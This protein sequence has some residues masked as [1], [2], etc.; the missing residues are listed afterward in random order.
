MGDVATGLALTDSYCNTDAPITNAGGSVNAHG[1]PKT[2]AELR[3]PTAHSTT[4]DETYYRWN[5]DDDGELTDLA[6]E[7]VWD[8][9]TS[10]QFPVLKADLDGDGVATV[11]EFGDQ[12]RPGLMPTPVDYDT[13]ND[14]LIE[15]CTL[16]QLDAIRY[17]LDGNGRVDAFAHEAAYGSAFPRYADTDIYGSIDCAG[18]CRGYELLK[19][20]DFEDANGDGT[21]GD[22]SIW[23]EGAVSAGVADAA[24]A[25]W[26]PIVKY[27]TSCISTPYSGIFD[28]NHRVI[29]NL[30]INDPNGSVQGVL[31]GL[32]SGVSGSI[33]NLGLEAANV[34]AD[35]I[36]GALVG[37]LVDAGSVRSCYA[38]GTVSTGGNDVAGGLIGSTF[39]RWDF[40]SPGSIVSCYA[41]VDVHSASSAMRVALW[42]L[43]ASLS[44][45]AM[46]RV[47]LVVT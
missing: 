25:G 3:T 7:I 29:H 14:G 28:G 2:S 19:D 43:L 13:D 47:L 41:S 22:K 36:T 27:D 21:P 40:G 17:D 20:L 16:S 23:A 46:R 31:G 34:T 18:G 35:G 24:E 39:R 1:T 9:G 15:V 38:T 26:P 42:L 5:R 6:D 32:F 33:H 4:A 12:G 37:N 45:A 8:F 44:W 10:T 11:L 30:Y